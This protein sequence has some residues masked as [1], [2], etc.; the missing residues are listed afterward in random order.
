M[1]IFHQSWS[2]DAQLDALFDQEP[3]KM[4]DH[5]IAM[6]PLV[7]R[8]FR[9]GKKAEGFALIQILQCDPVLLHEQSKSTNGPDVTSQRRWP[10]TPAFEISTELMLIIAKPIVSFA[11]D[12]VWPLDRKSVG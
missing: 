5:V 11:D 2:D 12:A 10:V 4:F 7:S 3:D 8:P 1:G 6:L 9:F